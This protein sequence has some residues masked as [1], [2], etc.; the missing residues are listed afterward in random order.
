MHKKINKTK[1]VDFKVNPAFIMASKNVH[2]CVWGETYFC[3]RFAERTDFMQDEDQ[4]KQS[5]QQE[6]LVET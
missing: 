5:L 2:K 3:C 1:V 4:M 6:P